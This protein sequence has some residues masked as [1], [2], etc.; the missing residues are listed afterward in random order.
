M[1]VSQGKGETTASHCARSCV[2][3]STQ[4]RVQ[5]KDSGMM[6]GNGVIIRPFQYYDKLSRFTNRQNPR[7]VCNFSYHAYWKN[8]DARTKTR[9][10]N[11]NENVFSVCNLGQSYIFRQWKN[12]LRLCSPPYFWG[13]FLWVYGHEYL[14]NQ[15]Q[16]LITARSKIERQKQLDV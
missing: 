7:Y 10:G 9:F 8:I 16:N 6:S 15:V 1:Q 2:A 13:G 14:W 5:C 3:L 12:F 4:C 11:L